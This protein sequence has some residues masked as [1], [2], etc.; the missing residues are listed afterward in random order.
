[1]RDA[2]LVRETAAAR[3]MLSR[4]AGMSEARSVDIAFDALE[5][6][7]SA[8]LA[9]GL[10]EGKVAPLGPINVARACGFGSLRRRCQRGA[11]LRASTPEGS[12]RACRL[13]N[14]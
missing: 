10:A 14:V 1:M 13:P 7:L 5:P 8:S 2:F 9:E 4:L 12:L 3:A 11:G 6:A